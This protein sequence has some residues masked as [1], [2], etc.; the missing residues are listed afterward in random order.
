MSTCQGPWSPNYVCTNFPAKETSQVIFSV[1]FEINNLNQKACLRIW[2]PCYGRKGAFILHC[3]SCSE[4]RCKKSTSDLLFFVRQNCFKFCRPSVPLALIVSVLSVG[5]N[6]ATLTLLNFEVHCTEH[7]W[8]ESLCFRYFYEV[9]FLTRS[10]RFSPAHPHACL[11]P[12]C[13]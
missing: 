3:H 11:T 2:K 5:L 13:R 12:S 7:G 4:C 6:S 1:I 10:S 8:R 9:S